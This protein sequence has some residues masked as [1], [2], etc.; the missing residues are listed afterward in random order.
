MVMVEGAS[1]RWR[2]SSACLPRDCVEVANREGRILVRDS[3]SAAG[4]V[5]E[6]GSDQWLI[7]V[8]TISS[9]RGNGDHYE[10]QRE[11]RSRPVCPSGPAE[12]TPPIRL[13]RG[14]RCPRDTG[15][16]HH[17]PRRER[18]SADRALGCCAGIGVGTCGT[19]LRPWPAERG[20]SCPA[21]GAAV[22]RPRRLIQFVSRMV[23]KTME[24]L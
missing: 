1:P 21:G 12:P 24:P 2:R 16:H 20:A 15:G 23:Q 5:L 10:W 11:V 3:A 4:T 18:N 13:L 22:A 19:C 9:S 8:R 14:I 6:F 17:G 7:F